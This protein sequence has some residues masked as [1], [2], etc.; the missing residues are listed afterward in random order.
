MPCFPIPF[1]FLLCFFFNFFN[2]FI[3]IYIYIFFFFF[4][5]FLFCFLF[6]NYLIQFNLINRLG[7]WKVGVDLCT[8]VCMY[9]RGR[10]G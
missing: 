3:Y 2:L 7:V 6:F 1:R 9:E 10:L 4:F 8:S 5:F